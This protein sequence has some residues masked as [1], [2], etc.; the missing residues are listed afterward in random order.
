MKKSIFTTLLLLMCLLSFSA[1][2]QTEAETQLEYDHQ[3]YQ[4]D[5]SEAIISDDEY[6]EIEDNIEEGVLHPDEGPA[7]GEGHEIGDHSKCT[8]DHLDIPEPGLLEVDEPFP[9]TDSE[10]ES[11]SESEGEGRVLASSS[12]FRIYSYYNF[13]APAY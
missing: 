5:Q 1:W 7:N 10:L 9:H 12:K 8:H 2:A 13:L 3:E 11:E 4:E 6:D